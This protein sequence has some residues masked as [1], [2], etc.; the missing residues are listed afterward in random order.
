MQ[1]STTARWAEGVLAP[2]ALLGPFSL[3]RLTSTTRFFQAFAMQV[4]SAYLPDTLGKNSSFPGYGGSCPIAV[5][6]C[7]KRRK[8]EMF[9][10]FSFDWGETHGD[11]LSCGGISVAEV[12]TSKPLSG[13]RQRADMLVGSSLLLLECNCCGRLVLQEK[14][15]GR[16]LFS[17]MYLV[18]QDLLSGADL[19]RMNVCFCCGLDVA[20]HTG[21]CDAG[22]RIA[23]KLLSR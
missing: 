9:R 3:A 14:K 20:Q 2:A 10:P 16:Q 6:S 11:V 8:R 13:T 15:N 5:R 22:V 7:G 12:S 17:C 18:E 21:V 23:S 4:M 1:A 19:H